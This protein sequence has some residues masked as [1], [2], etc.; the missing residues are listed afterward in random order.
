MWVDRS[1]EQAEQ[2]DVF[3]AY[4]GQQRDQ[5]PPAVYRIR[6]QK[7]VQVTRLN[8]KIYTVDCIKALK[9]P[10]WTLWCCPGD[11][12]DVPRRSNFWEA[13]SEDS[14]LA[15]KPG[16]QATLPARHDSTANSHRQRAGAQSIGTSFPV[17][18]GRD[19]AADISLDEAGVW[20][21]HFQ[22]TRQPQGVVCQVEKTPCFGSTTR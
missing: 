16:T 15:G 2:A 14:G 9:N 7:R 4:H 17:Q 11:R 1:T 10:N 20:P 3:G 12:I 13:W 5:R 21:R 8:G 18:V 6:G 22:I 19:A